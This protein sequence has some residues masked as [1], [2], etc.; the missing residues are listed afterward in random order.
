MPTYEDLIADNNFVDSVAYAYDEM[1]R[2]VPEDRQAL[3][4][5][6]LTYRR[7]YEDNIINTLTTKGDVDK[8]SED[9]KVLFNYAK[10]Q[11]D[12]LPNLFASEGG[13]PRL[14][15][16]FDHIKF[17]LTDPANAAT[18]LLAP[19]TL[20]SAGVAAQG[21]KIAAQTGIKA[22]VGRSIGRV[23]GT[24]LRRVATTL[25]NPGARKTLAAEGAINFGGTA[26]RENEIQNIE[27]DIGNRDKKNYGEI[28]TV[29]ALE[30]LMA[31]AIGLGGVAAAEIL[32]RGIKEGIDAGRRNSPSADFYINRMTNMFRPGGG[33]DMDIVRKNE[34]IRGAQTGFMK[35]SQGLEKELLKNSTYKELIKTQDGIN[36]LNKAVEGR[37][38]EIAEI[39][40]RDENLS[41]LIG[42]GRTLI[43]DVQE[44]AGKIEDLAPNVAKNFQKINPEFNPNYARF[45]YEAYEAPRKTKWKNY[46]KQNPDTIENVFETIK[47]DAELP[48][49]ESLKF[50]ENFGMTP[51]QLN[52][53]ALEGNVLRTVTQKTKDLYYGRSKNAYEETG[54]VLKGRKT[55]TEL[56]EVFANLLGQNVLPARRILASVRG[57]MEPMTQFHLAN[58]T[59]RILAAKGKATIIDLGSD[60]LNPKSIKQQAEEAADILSQQTGRTVDPSTLRPIHGAGGALPVKN[61]LRQSTKNY[62]VDRKLADDLRQTFTN[63]NMSS[64]TRGSGKTFEDEQVTTAAAQGMINLMSN[65]QGASKLFK[66]AYNPIAMGRNII[67][68]VYQLAG[69]GN[70]LGLL[71]VPKA[72]WGDPVTKKALYDLGILD[73]GVTM[74][75][76]LNRLGPDF[77][78]YT[79]GRSRAGVGPKTLLSADRLTMAA[80]KDVLKAPISQG[81]F[82]LTLRE[83]YQKVDDLAKVAAYTSE[84]R[85]VGNLWKTYSPEKQKEIRGQMKT[86]MGR[87]NVTDNEIISELAVRN[88]L[89]VMPTYSRVPQITEALR[90]IPVFG[91]F[92]GFQAEVIRNS[93]NSLRK[94]HQEMIEGFNTGNKTLQAQGANRVATLIGVNAGFYY[95]ITYLNESMMGSEEMTALKKFLAPWE[96]FSPLLITD[97]EAVSDPD[98]IDTEDLKISYKNMGWLNP[99]EPVMQLATAVLAMGQSGDADFDTL[100]DEYLA[101]SLRSIVAPFVDQ[102]LTVEAGKALAG[103]AL[104][105]PDSQ[106]FRGSAKKLVDLM[107]PG[108]A[109][110][111]KDAAIKQQLVGPE[112]RNLLDPRYY[113]KKREEADLT[114]V[115]GMVEFLQESGAI[116]SPEKTFSIKSEVGFALQEVQRQA[117]TPY[118]NFRSKA[119]MLFTDPTALD[120]IDAESLLAEYEDSI[121]DQFAAQQNYGDL[122]RDLITLGGSKQFV[123][124]MMKDPDLKNSAF[125]QSEAGKQR[126]INDVSDISRLSNN[127]EFWKEVYRENRDFPVQEMKQA[128]RSLED[129]YNNIDLDV[130]P[131]QLLE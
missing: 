39:A 31:P 109:A 44:Y 28:G 88:A 75:Q 94:G 101:P 46:I 61:G 50:Y 123:R 103:I 49:G 30:T 68:A 107:L 11:A 111:I 42:K 102:S 77:A 14:K 74:N 121:Q 71:K 12:A 36:L 47:R 131:K 27:V 100:V 17:S 1:G 104:E 92:M 82:G 78:T 2:E 96:R 112:T 114:T 119:R 6:F 118:L 59:G 83:A 56:P 79:G 20:G 57:I 93:I 126:A 128:M 38:K 25:K 86:F 51:S 67:G 80:L 117:K 53:A 81:G 40:G 24:P 106:K 127:K 34:V 97:I 13:A 21:A 113:D 48:E 43:A 19:F 9:G 98:N 99:Y 52:S 15:G 65:V 64:L 66:T 76:I 110:L 54:S 108:Y 124:R 22:A 10:T 72:Y 16:I 115:G 105:D 120:E 8:L 26:F 5:D 89:D 125:P 116:L 29:A 58:E 37:G 4:D 45:I 7:A 63:P 55:D 3:V 84:Q 18:I 87:E 129:H 62:F 91:N 33:L 32:G 73:T 41:E 70:A 85:K 60:P 95:G 23:V 35:T 90:G 122:M 130:E 69:T